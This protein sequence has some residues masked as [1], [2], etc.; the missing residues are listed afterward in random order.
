MHA[1]M[2]NRD[3]KR[4]QSPIYPCVFVFYK[5]QF[6][7]IYPPA[8]MCVAYTAH[9]THIVSALFVFFSLHQLNAITSFIIYHNQPETIINNSNGKEDDEEQKL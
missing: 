5:L 9:G 6:R 7:A 3:F 8:R 4:K 2:Q 1:V